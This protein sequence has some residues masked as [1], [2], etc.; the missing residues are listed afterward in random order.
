M[1][2]D[3]DRVDLSALEPRG[4]PAV[5]DATLRRLDATLTSRRK[6]PLTLIAS[7]SRSLTIGAGVMVAVLIPV[8]LALEVREGQAEPVQRLVTLSTRAALGAQSPTGEELS[9]AL[10]HDLLR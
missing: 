1:N 9:R 2:N 6:D 5:L 3:Q 7:W 8:E 4:W 10:G